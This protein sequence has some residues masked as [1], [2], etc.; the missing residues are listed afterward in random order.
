MC[1]IYQTTYLLDALIKRLQQDFVKTGGIKEQMP[2][3]RLDY[4]KNMK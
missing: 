4:R 2:K 1:F 3:A